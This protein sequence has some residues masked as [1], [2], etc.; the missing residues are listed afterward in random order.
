MIAPSKI[1]ANSSVILD[2]SIRLLIIIQQ[3]LGGLYLALGQSCMLML[4]SMPVIGCPC[5][6]IKRLWIAQHLL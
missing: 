1:K 5:R 2:S 3:F 4:V 6:T